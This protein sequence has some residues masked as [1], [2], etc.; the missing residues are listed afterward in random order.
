MSLP[1]RGPAVDPVA[2]ATQLFDENYLRCFWHMRRDL[3]FTRESIYLVLK[4]LRSEGGRQQWLDA[5][6]LEAMLTGSPYR[7]SA[8]RMDTGPWPAAAEAAINN[9]WNLVGHP[10]IRDYIDLLHCHATYLS[11]GAVAWAASAK[12]PALNPVSMLEYAKRHTRYTH[13][14]LKSVPHGPEVTLPGLKHR[15]L[16]AVDQAEALFPRLPAEELGC[17]YLNAD[18]TP[19]TPDPDSPAFLALPRHYGSVR[20][21]WPTIAS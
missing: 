8:P 18:G 6:S 17:L 11:L 16:A 12:E 2:R 13:D 7:G 1:E 5:A 4:G 21:A 9:L 20:G 14:E 19:V 10:S 15:W 3:A